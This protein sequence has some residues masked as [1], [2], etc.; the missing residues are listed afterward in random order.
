[1]SAFV[2]LA[3]ATLIVLVSGTAR[4]GSVH[5]FPITVSLAQGK[6]LGALRDSMGPTKLIM[7]GVAV[8]TS[9]AYC[10]V[11]DAAGAYASCNVFSDSPLFPGFVKNVRA[12]NSISAVALW[13]DSV[14][15]RCT[16]MWLSN[17]SQYL[18]ES[19][20]PGNSLHETIVDPARG[21]ASASITS[22]RHI[23][24]GP[25]FLSCEVFASGQVI[26]QARNENWVH[27]SCITSE[28]A[29]PAFAE[30]V[31]SIDAVSLVAFRFDPVQYTCT[32]ISVTKSSGMLRP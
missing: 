18:S 1:M 21:Y 4:A 31:R 9:S 27:V 24:E 22:A 26:C 7:C 19:Q 20:R 25:E 3:C 8:D 6:A 16:D 32:D 2:R 28:A 5:D 23:G 11:R 14:T 13:W 10:N 15:H 17:G 29:N 12:L 30:A